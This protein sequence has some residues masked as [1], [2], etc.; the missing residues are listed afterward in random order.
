MII[1]L[2]NPRNGDFCE[3]LYVGTV[4]MD[5]LKAMTDHAEKNNIP[6]DEENHY[7]V[8]PFDVRGKMT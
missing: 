6:A 5:G 8:I 4:A 7:K 1:L 2:F 3:V